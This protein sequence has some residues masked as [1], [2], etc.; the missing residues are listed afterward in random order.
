[1]LKNPNG[2]QFVPVPRDPL[3]AKK[4][5]LV[6]VLA[7]ASFPYGVSVSVMMFENE[8]AFFDNRQSHTAH[9]GKYEI[10]VRRPDLFTLMHEVALEF[11]PG[12]EVCAAPE[13]PEEVPSPP[14]DD[15]ASEKALG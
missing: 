10:N 9:L 8:Q 13:K 2:S 14:A 11:F 4:C 5:E 15:V 12:F 1:M 7:S 3:T 6:F